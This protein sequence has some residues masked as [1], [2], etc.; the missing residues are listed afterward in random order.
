MR[1]LLRIFL[2]LAA[3][4]S[5][6]GIP[7]GAHAQRAAFQ[8]VSS[9]MTTDEAFNAYNAKSTEAP[10]TVQA[11]PVG[12]DNYGYYFHY[13]GMKPKKD[14]FRVGFTS[15]GGEVRHGAVHTFDDAAGEETLAIPSDTMQQPGSY[16]ATLY[17]D[18]KSAQSVSF[19]V[20]VTPKIT[21]AY[22]ITEKAWE[23]FGSSSKSNPAKMSSFA[24]GV[25]RVGVFISYTGMAKTD[26]HYVGVYNNANGSQVHR[27]DDATSQYVPSGAVAIALPDDAGSYPKGTYRTDIYIDYAMVKSITWTVK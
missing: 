26:V 20:I 16:K 19:K 13:R 3:L 1:T 5:L 17:I 6:A 4:G 22:M 24:A 21:S 27:S 25:A 9:Y 12:V 14:T 15:K 11:F 10:P 23:A 7:A 2:A 18:D 8:I